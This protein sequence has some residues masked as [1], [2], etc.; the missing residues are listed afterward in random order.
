M[1]A[2]TTHFT[3]VKERG[4]QYTAR[5]D[6]HAMYRVDDQESYFGVIRKD[7]VVVNAL[8]G[9]FNIS[10]DEAFRRYVNAYDLLEG[11]MDRIERE[12]VH[13]DGRVV[14]RSRSIII[15]FDSDHS[16]FIGHRVLVDDD[17]GEPLG[18]TVSASRSENLIS[19]VYG[20]QP[21]NVGLIS[22]S[23]SPEQPQS[24]IA[25]EEEEEEEEEEEPLQRPKRRRDQNFDLDRDMDMN[26]SIDRNA[27]IRLDITA[28]TLHSN[29]TAAASRPLVSIANSCEGRRIKNHPWK[30]QDW[31]SSNRST[32][33]DDEIM[34]EAGPSA[35]PSNRGLYGISD[36]SRSDEAPAGALAIALLNEP[37]LAL[38]GLTE[39]LNLEIM[40]D[41]HKFNRATIAAAL[42]GTRYQTEPKFKLPDPTPACFAG[43]GRKYLLKKKT[44][45]M[46]GP[47]LP[48]CPGV[49][50]GWVSK[51]EG[52]KVDGFLLFF[53]KDH[54]EGKPTFYFGT[55]KMVHEDA[56]TA[57]Q[58]A[59]LPGDMRESWIQ[60]VTALTSRKQ[61]LSAC[62]VH[63][64]L[65]DD[66]SEDDVRDAFAEGHL[67]LGYSVIACVEYDV[68]VPAYIQ[69]HIGDQRSGP[70]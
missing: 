66:A 31:N 52:L 23:T 53:Q 8:R 17:D 65:S 56:F 33:D 48:G 21:R 9:Q 55:Y 3:I 44:E 67:Q 61:W 20:I 26:M 36:L 54:G 24:Q 64:P 60:R 7:L 18:R 46:L 39:P 19:A 6:H 38:F 59:E 32:T 58:W 42:G 11:G 1:S 27:G 62:R 16:M 49:V 63:A 2:S 51:Q 5:G 37:Y 14:I 12:G 45:S 70:V 13:A 15:T 40:D 22:P 35:G 41:A 28:S 50:S 30:V 25:S 29:I 57:E 4:F 10:L 47:R 69:Q 34:S 43:L 68:R